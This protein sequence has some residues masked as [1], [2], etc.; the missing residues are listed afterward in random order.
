MLDGS[1]C[2]YEEWR[3]C[4]DDIRPRGVGMRGCN[5]SANGAFVTGM[6]GG[7]ST[8]KGTAVM[9]LTGIAGEGMLGVG[10]SE[11]WALLGII[12]SRGRKVDVAGWGW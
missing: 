2:E 7:D 8:G 11:G 4:D 3:D 6:V 12:H 10:G 9:S 1:S 5:P